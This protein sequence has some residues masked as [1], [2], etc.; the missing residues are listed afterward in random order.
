[1]RRALVVVVGCGLL[2][3]LALVGD[4]A[5]AQFNKPAPPGGPGG[6]A[7]GDKPGPGTGPGFNTDYADVGRAI[8]PVPPNAQLKK[9]LEAAADY[10]RTHD[11]VKVAEILQNLLDL[12]SDSFVMSDVKGPDGKV[13]QVRVG[14]KYAANRMLGEL[15]AEGMTA[16]R[17]QHD[18]NA[19]KKLD[20]AIADGDKAKFA[21]VA[22][23]YLWTESGGEAADRLASY[24][25]DRGEFMM[26]AQA[27]DRLAQ[28]VG[29]ENLEPA[30]LF[31]MAIAYEKSGTK[32]DAEKKE[33]VWK[34]AQAKS[35]DGFQFG[36]QL[37]SFEDAQKFIAS[38]KAASSASK[39]G[40]SMF[41]GDESRNAL[42][43][44]GQPFLQARWR[45]S[46]LVD[47]PEYSAINNQIRSWLWDG[48]NSASKVLETNNKPVLPAFY[49]IAVTAD[50][51]GQPTPVVVYRTYEGIAAHVLKGDKH[52]WDTPSSWSLQKM[53]VDPKRASTINSWVQQ[54][55][56]NSKPQVLLENST[57]GSLSSDG[58]RV[59]A[60]EDMA[61][62]NPV[63][64]QWDPRFGMPPPGITPPSE[65]NDGVQHSR[66]RAFG[67]GSG[68]LLWELGGRPANGETVTNDPKDFR[69]THFVGAP[70]CLGGKI[71]FM[72]EKKENLNL[73]CMDPARVPRRPTEKDLQD[74]IL[75]VQPL[76]S[77]KTKITSDYMRRI[78]A[79]HIACGEGVLVCPTN[80]GVV[81][82]V[83]L[84][85]H[86][87]IWAYAY[88]TG[89]PATGTNP[90]D[91]WGG[92]G[93][94][95]RP[96]PQPNNGTIVSEWKTSAPIVTE[97]KVIFTAPD[98]KA[99]ACLSLRNGAKLWSV[100]RTDDKMFLGGV[101]NG[102]A[103]V[104][105]RSHVEAYSLENGSVVWQAET[106]VPS[107][108]G[109]A[110]NGI[111]YLPVKQIPSLDK[112]RSPGIVA[113]NMETGQVVATTRA[114][115]NGK[116]EWTEYPGNLT[117]FDGYV[118]AQSAAE[119]AVYPQL[120]LQER[121]VAT[122]LAKNPDD[123]VGLYKRGELHLDKGERL[124]AVEDLRSALANKPPKEEEAHVRERLFES[125][126]ELLQ[127]EFDKGETYIAQY[128][129]LCKAETVPETRRRKA[130]FLSLMAKGRESQRK[131]GEALK[132][133]L[134]FGALASDDEL[135][136]VVDEPLVRAR[137]DVWARARITSM[138]RDAKPAE[139]E[140]L[141]KV[142]VEQINEAR[143]GDDLNKLRRLVGMFGSSSAGKEARLELA[144]RMAE[145]GK[146]SLLD[147]ERELLM[148]R[149][150]EDPY[151]AARATDGLARLMMRHDLLEN[152][153]KLYQDLKRDYPNVKVRDGKTG[154]E[155]L[156]DLFADKRFYQFQD[157]QQ[158]SAPAPKPAPPA[159]GEKRTRMTWRYDVA[160]NGNFAQ[161]PQN[162][163][164]TLEPEN[165]PLPSIRAMRVAI[166]YNTNYLKL[167]D[168]QSG[169]ELMSEH[170]KN[171]PYI[172]NYIQQLYQLNNQVM[173][174]GSR[175]AEGSYHFGYHSA[176]HL[177][178]MSVGQTVIAVD[179]LS[180]KI[181]WEKSLLGAQ[182]AGQQVNIQV[183]YND[184]TF[185]VMTQTGQRINLGQ[186]G[187]VTPS[188][189][190]ILTRDGL[191]AYEPLT[192]KTLWTRT[193]VPLRAKVF[194]DDKHIFVVE[195]GDQGQP[196]S[197]RAFRAQDGV[198]VN[199]P[200]FDK[201][202]A[203]RVRVMGRSLLVADSTGGPGM[204]LK[205][206]DIVT[207][208][209]VW[210]KTFPAGSVVL[211]S[212]D[213][214]LSGAVDPDGN[215]TIVNLRTQKSMGVLLR[216]EH[217]KKIQMAYL[218]QD[219]Q[220]FYVTTY[221]PDG[222]VAGWGHPQ[223]NVN[224]YSGMRSVPVSGGIYAY[225]KTSGKLK[226]IQECENQHLILDNW[227]ESPV[228]FLTSRYYSNAG[229]F[230]GMQSVGVALFDKASGK[231]IYEKKDLGQQV[232]QF[233]GFHEAK[234][235]KL[236]FTANN[237]KI[238]IWQEAEN[239]AAAKDKPKDEGKPGAGGAGN[240]S[241]N[242][243]GQSGGS[244]A[245]DAP[246]PPPLPVPPI[247]GRGRILP[248]NGAGGAMIPLNGTTL[249][250]L[251]VA[252]DTVETDDER[253]D[254]IGVLL[255]T[256]AA[257]KQTP[258]E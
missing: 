242:G 13:T 250:T 209:D 7:T 138:I 4:S 237:Y 76:C 165:E 229:R 56:S 122:L 175:I 57:L 77:P 247:R 23:R 251:G 6:P 2:T 236:E 169:K 111:Y 52:L 191:T 216:P 22:F 68:L 97:G 30:T 18:Q 20:D 163:L 158:Q 258:C 59:F 164:Y 162:Q 134:E 129:E 248:P 116:N 192:G 214:D 53:M 75:W 121:E 109:V 103:L 1:M 71:F 55:L 205:L 172:N 240:G 123:P 218:M 25:L 235:G 127:R 128:E 36:G 98:G 61:I 84:L 177:L 167:V 43:I 60:V 150:D 207:G 118:I 178:V 154:A 181:L 50:I 212:E 208:K 80:S 200:G 16:Y 70:L 136:P 38:I 90:N 241:S 48:G 249:S 15:P 47:R 81:L 67:I 74:A 151:Y 254:V 180:K 94:R 215:A 101:H 110:S 44:G 238:T 228:L 147:S 69:D 157:A 130:N 119:I 46:L 14:L 222:N 256:P 219:G 220:N 88:E 86:S 92:G 161:G 173:F 243:A 95:G 139:R 159:E 131:L 140:S 24:A 12:S 104:V 33:K 227:K 203:Q 224:I 39:D 108:R 213:P 87:L 182:G 166:N 184:G 245:T 217:V 51:K 176:G 144:D 206:Y 96:Y 115:K 10:V 17:L 91:P 168:R 113:V 105:T 186:L 226:W 41:G 78:S 82:G 170:L 120:E 34:L 179:P 190:T 32:D 107:G 3:C 132:Y 21:E 65:V 137:P 257:V 35:P 231:T 135:M 8:L 45:E 114:R 246:I 37:V 100:D 133:Y 146:A 194:G 189:V 99:L 148:L 29:L 193:D 141:E 125:M 232:Q 201:L 72:N 210:S 196:T 64:Q 188:S 11:W 143:K 112:E 93:F 221:A 63:I 197:S 225:G 40:S 42:S 28:R 185:W 54:F 149:N 183:D 152:A 5:D 117:F 204:T 234:N 27:F 195:I 31:K 102:R 199:V 198:T 106:G 85:S 233:F 202:F 89:I 79:G 244:G 58:V 62:P 153:F 174:N 19:K 124:A 171:S 230:N 142:I 66:L 239:A 126:T 155:L 26:A 252:L 49:P 9:S 83:D 253:F 156:E 145:G 187:P 211:R 73:V 223:P 255:A 160:Q